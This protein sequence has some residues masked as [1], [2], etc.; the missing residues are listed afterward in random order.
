MAKVIKEVESKRITVNNDSINCGECGHGW[1][2]D[3]PNHPT[4]ESHMSKIGTPCDCGR[5][6]KLVKSSYER[7]IKGYKVIECKTCS[8]HVNL[9]SSWANSCDKCDSEY[10]GA[11]QLLAPRDHWG[12]E[13]GETFY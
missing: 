5:P 13:T 4:Y 10:N 8:G 6:L 3:D 7:F 9:I 1:S 11:G 12:E 2:V